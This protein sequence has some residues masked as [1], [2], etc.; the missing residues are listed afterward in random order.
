MNRL[1]GKT[2]IVTGGGQRGADG[3]S[4]GTASAVPGALVPQSGGSDAALSVVATAEVSPGV[5]VDLGG[6]E[7]STSGP[8]GQKILCALALGGTGDGPEISGGAASGVGLLR[9]PSPVA[10]PSAYH[11][12]GRGLVQT[13]APL[14]QPLPRLPRCRAQRA[15][16]GLLLARHR[17]DAPLRSSHDLQHPLS[18]FQ[19]KCWTVPR[20]MED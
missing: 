18:Y 20:D 14:L 3:V 16:A 8:V 4:R 11:Q 17:T 9:F 7:R 2:A 10:T 6:G 12:S 15:S 19:Q 5:L 13:L 1:P